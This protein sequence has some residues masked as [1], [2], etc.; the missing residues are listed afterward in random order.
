[1]LLVSLRTRL[2]I[3]GLA[4]FEILSWKTEQE[5]FVEIAAKGFSLEKKKDQATPF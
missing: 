2:A 5:G 3:L 1:M 4:Q